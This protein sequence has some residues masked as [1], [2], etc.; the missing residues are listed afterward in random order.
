MN[1]KVR[2]NMYWLVASVLIIALCVT[3]ARSVETDFGKVDVQIIKIVDPTGVVLVGKLYRPVDA[4]PQHKLPAVLTLHGYQN[5]KETMDA[6]AIE[7]SRR[8]FVVLALDQFG[9]GDSGGALRMRATDPTIGGNTGYQYLKSLPF[10]DSSNI[11]VM[12][13]SMGALSTIAVGAANPDVKALNPQCGVAGSPALHNL[14]LTQAKYDEF[15]I[16]RENQL[17]TQNLPTNPNRLKALGLPGPANWDTLYGDFSK[18]TAREQVLIDTVHPGVTHNSKAVAAAV[19]WM[20]EALK[21]GQKD[22]SWIPSNQ[23]IYMVKEFATLLALLIALFSII[24]L[25]NILL[26]TSYFKEVAQPMPDRYVAK[27]TSWLVLAIVN[28]LIAGITYP[29]LT[30]YGGLTDKVEKILPWFQLPMGNG[31]MLWFLGNAII[32]AI[33]F[34]IWYKTSGKRAGVT[35]YDMG[36]SF[37]KDRTTFDWRILGKTLL[38]GAILFS[39]MYLLEGIS[40]WSTGIEFRF[41]WPFMRQFSAHRFLLFLLYLIP[42]LLFFLLNGGVFLFGQARQKEYGTP[43]LTTVIWWLK[44]TFAAI[45]G[46]VL[47]WL[48]QYVPFFLN[49]GPGFELMGLPQYSQMWPLMIFV[50][51]PEFIPLVFLLTWF[52]RRTGKVYLG[53]LMVASIAIWFTAAGSVIL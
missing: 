38:L 13:H 42:A 23:Q 27:G 36:V 12:G 24:P 4:T 40:Q 6:S 47:V 17:T 45:F 31:V 3:V 46:L 2:K 50:F 9:Q 7:L 21:G 15:M 1:P 49:K 11:G 39:W 34:T 20:E 26:E 44:N 32:Y 16:F 8:G 28:I 25:A 22:S 41:L 29:I 53:A 51:V 43:A 14:L 30:A 5:D 18:G 33:L 37:D 10:V 52:F 19:D 48:V 35:M